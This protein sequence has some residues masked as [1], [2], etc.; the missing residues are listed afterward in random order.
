MQALD[1]CVELGCQ[2]CSLSLML[3]RSAGVCVR[4]ALF[5]SV[6]R[7]SSGLCSV[8]LL[9]QVPDHVPWCYLLLSTLQLAA[10]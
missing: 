3:L 1:A 2:V 8:P 6:S 4:L 5:D 10:A 9:S 7:L